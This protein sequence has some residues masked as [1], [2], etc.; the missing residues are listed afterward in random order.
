MLPLASAGQLEPAL[1]Q[2]GLPAIM[3]VDGTW[4][5]LGVRKVHSLAEARHMLRGLAKPLDAA[6]AIKRLLV[7]RD[8]YSLAPWLARDRPV[9][10]IQRFVS[11]RPAN[12]AVACWQGQVL[13]CIN[14]EVLR[15]RGE[16]GA[17]TVVR[18]IENREMTEASVKL[19][20]RL[21]LSGLC[22]FDFLIEESTG[23]AHL[24]E[25][26]GRATPLSHLP[27]GPGRDPVRALSTRLGG[28]ID[29]RPV[30]AIAQDVIAFFPQAWHL[31][32]DCEYLTQ[33]YHDVPWEEPDLVMDLMQRPWPDR[34][35]AARFDRWFRNRTGNLFSATGNFGEEPPQEPGSEASYQPKMPA[36]GE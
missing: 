2:V 23:A 19:V 25:M 35:L 24:L 22:G 12:N 26:N 3:K 16:R 11:G 6:R 9:V 5:G 1:A 21:N 7:H 28:T 34:N 33:G 32:P 30:P 20:R 29:A 18:V 31:E 8:P 17:S 4:G 15:A 36:P 10:N 13:A 27:L 14:V